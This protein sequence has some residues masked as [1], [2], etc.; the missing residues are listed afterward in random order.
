VN[1]LQASDITLDCARARY[2]ADLQHVHPL[3]NE[4]MSDVL[5]VLNSLVEKETSPVMSRLDAARADYLKCLRDRRR[6]HNAQVLEL[7]KACTDL[8]APAIGLTAAPA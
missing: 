5:Q 1:E 7:A 3:F 4:Q 8:F 6:T 2:L